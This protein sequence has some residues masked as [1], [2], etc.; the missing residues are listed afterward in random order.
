MRQ[1]SRVCIRVGDEEHESVVKVVTVR[2][3]TDAV[4][5]CDVLHRSLNRTS[6]Y[7]C[8]SVHACLLYVVRRDWQVGSWERAD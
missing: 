6:S 8:V 3:L 7:V 2:C 4:R 1:R 5:K